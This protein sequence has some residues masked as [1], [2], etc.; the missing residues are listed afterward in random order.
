MSH[1]PEPVGTSVPSR[2][3]SEKPQR[4][5]GHKPASSQ[6]RH[7]WAPPSSREHGPPASAAR[8][9]ASTGLVVWLNVWNPP[10]RT[11]EPQ[12]ELRGS[13]CL[14]LVF[15]KYSPSATLFSLPYDVL[16]NTFSSSF[17]CYK[18]KI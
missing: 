6:L 9:M 3:S 13:P 8:L 18:D 7:P 15:S 14:Q 11:L 12:S 10:Q 5:C 4:L 2:P 16:K 17:H 1:Q